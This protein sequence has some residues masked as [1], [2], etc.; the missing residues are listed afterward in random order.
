[1]K[2]LALLALAFFFIAAPIYLK[3]ETRGLTINGNSNPFGQAV[4]I[5][6]KWAVP[7]DQFLMAFG[8]NLTMEQAGFTRKGNSLWTVMPIDQA[9]GKHIKGQVKIDPAANKSS[10][11]G[12]VFFVR[13]AGEK[14]GDIIPFNNRNYIGISEV[15]KALGG[16]FTA[17]ANPQQGQSL[18]L[19]FAPNPASI[20]GYQSGGHGH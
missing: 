14:I 11:G 20:L 9:S 13:K 19:N 6:N 7:V 15:A 17:P 2:R 5:G 3:Y 16:T 4:L 8:G 12:G 1:M 18:T 10:L